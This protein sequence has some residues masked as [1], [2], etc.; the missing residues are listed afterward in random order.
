MIL[1]KSIM[2]T[3]EY[4][5]AQRKISTIGLKSL[6]WL[7]IDWWLIDDLLIIEWGFIEVW[8]MIDWWLI[9]DLMEIKR[10]WYDWIEINGNGLK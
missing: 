6:S 5:L 9:D 2:I 4:I 1:T 8:M 7:M 10:S 3:V